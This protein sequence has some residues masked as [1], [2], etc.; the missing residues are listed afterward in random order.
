LAPS[1][2][3]GETFFQHEKPFNPTELIKFRKRIGEEGS[4]KMLK[5]SINL[6]GKSE[7]E[8]AE[9]CISTTKAFR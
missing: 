4:E 3:V 5:L 2:R 8:E 6:F 9:V 1:T 7:I